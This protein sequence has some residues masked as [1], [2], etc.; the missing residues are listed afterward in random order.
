MRPPQGALNPPG[1]RLLLIYGVG[2]AKST[3]EI[4]QLEVSK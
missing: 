1:C 2:E 3:I 4:D